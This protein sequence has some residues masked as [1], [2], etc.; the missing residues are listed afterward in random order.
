[1]TLSIRNLRFAPALALLAASGWV[2]AQSSEPRFQDY[3]DGTV[4]DNQT[5]LTWAAEDNG[6][7]I[8]WPKAQQYCQSKGAGWR[9][10]NVNELLRLYNTEPDDTQE[11]VGLLTCKITPKIKVSGLTMWSAEQNTSS[12]AWYVYF[13]DGQ[14]YAY[15]VSSTQGKRALCVK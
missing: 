2:C 10:P 7:D 13:N 6:N 15:S 14:Q 8:D 5:G 11:C 9:L 12:E 1:M 4:K 3:N